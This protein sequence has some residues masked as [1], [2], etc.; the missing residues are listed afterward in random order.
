MKVYVKCDKK[1]IMSY[2][3]GSNPKEWSVVQVAAPANILM[4]KFCSDMPSV[5]QLRTLKIQAPAVDEPQTMSAVQPDQRVSTAVSKADI[6]DAKRKCAE[7]GFV[8]GTP[9]FG[10]CVL[11][12]TQ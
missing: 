3:E 7:L 4:T 6:E 2:E 12:L 9:K 1:Q 10:Q 8:A 5:A 11:K